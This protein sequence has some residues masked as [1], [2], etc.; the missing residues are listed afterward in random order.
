MRYLRVMSSTETTKTAAVSHADLV[1]LNE[2]CTRTLTGDERHRALAEFK[3]RGSMRDAFLAREDGQ[4]EDAPE[5]WGP[6]MD[7][8]DWA[9]FDEEPGS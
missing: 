2:D 4:D 5:D 9:G 7:A 1:V 8:I 6:A 3:A